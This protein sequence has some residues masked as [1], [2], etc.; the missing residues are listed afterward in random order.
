MGGSDLKQRLAAILAADVAGYSRLMAA[1]E[2]ATVVALDAARGAFKS[3]IDAH[4]GRVIDMAGDSVLAVF[5]TA[6]GAVSAALAIQ[7]ELKGLIG[8]VPEDR[9]MRFRIGVHLGD[10]IEKSDGTVYGDGVNIAARLEGI[11]Q[12]GGITVSDAIQG[13]VRGKVT[14]SFIDQGEQTVKNIAHPLRAF[15]VVPQGQELPANTPVHLKK[16]SS[17]GSSIAVLAFDNMSGDPEQ[18]YF[19][20]GIS[21]DIIT[22]LSKI[23]G[24]AV[25]GRHSS[26]AYKGKVTD[27]RRIG[28]ELGVRYVLEGSARKV[29]NHVRVTAQLIEAETG[30]HIWANRYDRE[31]ENVFLVGDEIAED[32][33]TSLDV[34]LGR[35]EDAR[36]WN[37]ALKSADARDAFNRG[38]SAYRLSTEQDNRKGRDLFLEVIRLEPDSATGYAYVAG[39]HVIDVIQ[40]WSN[41]PGKSLEEAKR[42]SGKAIELDDTSAGGHFAHAIVALFEGSHQAALAEGE[43]GLELRPMCSAPKAGLAYIQL[44]SG[45]LDRALGNAREAI[46]LNPIFPAWYLYLMSAAQYFGGRC[47]EA[48]STLSQVLST[49]PRLSFARLLRIAVLSALNRQEEAR[50]ERAA[51]LQDH[52]GFS[53]ARFS[54]T[55]PFY[56]KAK[57]DGYLGALRAVGL[58]D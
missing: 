44:Y 21:E 8:N 50:A 29:G 58:P 20:D 37:K 47:E 10:V 39:T 45:I 33:V 48:L 7:Q 30:T 24:L 52:P 17:G 4:Q 12:P 15:R 11:A 23:N 16:P 35:G 28:R 2:R 54:R 46:E 5:E 3:Q 53:L 56:D 41:D 14:A 18:E 1:D 55:Q 32:I 38:W 42:L 49:N 13:A 31:M 25:I 36:I 22:D 34:K 6:T 9:R 57:L 26:F 27:L 40:G 19:C 43:R 51:F